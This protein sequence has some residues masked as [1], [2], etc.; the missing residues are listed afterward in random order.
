MAYLVSPCCGDKE[1]TDIYEHG[2]ETFV[3]SICK[4]SFEEA[5]E[6]Y[7]YD[8]RIKESIAEDRMDEKRDLGL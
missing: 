4:E 8:E 5:E 2:Y 1:Y 3:C 6:D 7:E